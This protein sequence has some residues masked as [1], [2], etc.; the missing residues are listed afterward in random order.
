MINIE[1]T[2]LEIAEITGK[3]HKHGSSIR[4]T[5]KGKHYIAENLD[6]INDKVNAHYIAL[7][8]IKQAAI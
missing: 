2:S 8:E 7:Q 3:E 4:M 5:S 6:M 1:M